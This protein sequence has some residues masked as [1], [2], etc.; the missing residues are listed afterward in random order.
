MS[1]RRY[2]ELD[3]TYRNRV[4]YPKPSVFNVEIEQR[5]NYVGLQAIDPV[6]LASPILT[7]NT[8]FNI[9]SNSPTLSGTVDSFT[10]LTSGATTS[11]YLVS[12]VAPLNSLSREDNYY[13]G[14]ILNNT[15]LG[16]RR[17]IEAYE[18]TKTTGGNDYGFFYLSQPFSDS[19][20]GGDTVTI[21]NPTDITDTSNPLFFI[22]TGTTAPNYYIGYL[23]YNET[24]NQYRT[25]SEYD[26]LTK[27]ARLDTTTNG[28]GAITGWLT[29]HQY[30]LR[31]EP[32]F[33]ND[34]ILAGSTES[35]VVLSASAS[36]EDN[37]YNGDF[38]RF[39]SG[40][41]DNEIRRIISY[42]GT[43]KTVT[44]NPPFSFIPSAGDTIELLKFS[45]DNYKPFSY[46]GS[47]DS[48]QQSVCYEIC[49]EDIILPNIVL[50]S[51][52]GSRLAFYPYVYVEFRCKSS[53]GMTD[54]IIYSNNPNSK[55][56][57]FR[58]PIDDIQNPVTSP[59]IHLSGEGM[60]QTVKF[61]PNSNLEFS[62][63]LPNGE[64]LS[65]KLKDNYS[66]LPPEPR[67]QISALFSIKRL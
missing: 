51:G 22:P 37:I 8:D 59:F 47:L 50:D 7:F 4:L 63:F 26:S 6:S 20:A 38:I 52:F 66:P 30:S 39:T 25:I 28:G 43:T 11:P 57:L 19:L 44:V 49:L 64:D 48:Q 9:I 65:F 17:R 55:K 16:E 14:A 2:I 10:V 18:Y 13:R 12:I 33:Y 58:V 24:L 36:S 54:G 35:T 5:E 61:K 1:N 40:V 45:Y 67:V 46:N 23:L 31:K 32:P 21:S 60:V 42:N 3:S 53:D 27:L 29:T 15:T 41:N 56:A 62:V 34:T